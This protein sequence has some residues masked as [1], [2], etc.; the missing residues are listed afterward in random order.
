MRSLDNI[1]ANSQP[2][3]RTLLLED[4]EWCIYRREQDRC[5]MI[6]RCNIVKRAQ[7]P[8]DSS[9]HGCGDA[10]PVALRGLFILNE[11]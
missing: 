9:C 6:H 5:Y 11:W 4:G 8:T 7:T 1:Y 10:V 2:A 3:K